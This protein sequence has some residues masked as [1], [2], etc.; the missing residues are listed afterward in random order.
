MAALLLIGSVGVIGYLTN[1]VLLNK[2]SHNDEVLHTD[3]AKRTAEFIKQNNILDSSYIQENFETDTTKPQDI[4]PNINNSN[5]V[6]ENTGS[7]DT[8]QDATKTNFK[9]KLSGLTL[10]QQELGSNDQGVSFQPFYNGRLKQNMRLDQKHANLGWMTGTDDNLM[11][12]KEIAKNMF[13]PVKNLSSVNGTNIYNSDLKHRYNSSRYISGERPFEQIR[14]GPGLNKGYTTEGSGGFHQGNTRDYVMPKNV[15]QLRTLDN[16]KLTY[17]GR[18]AAPKVSISKRGKQ[19]LVFK[20][21]VERTFNQSHEDLLVTTGAVIR[22]AGRSTIIIK[23]T[24]RKLSG[25]IMGN[26]KYGVNSNILPGNFE[27][28]TKLTYCKDQARNL[29]GEYLGQ[30][31]AD[32]HGKKSFFLDITKRNV[33][34]L[35]THTTNVSKAVKALITPI[36]D[37]FK[38]TIKETTEANNN[39]GNVGLQ[40]FRS[41]MKDKDNQQMNPTQRETLEQEETFRNMLSKD[42]KNYVHDPSDVLKT[43]IKQTTSD[44]NYIGPAASSDEKSGYNLFDKNNFKTSGSR[45]E[46]LEGREPTTSNVS[47]TSGASNLNVTTGKNDCLYKNDRDFT[48]TNMY[49]VGN[50]IEQYRNTGTRLREEMNS[51]RGNTDLIQ[52]L[53]NNPYNLSI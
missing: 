48:K 14:V 7:S 5:T 36:T 22:E 32:D 50:N 1:K 52:Q 35:R 26:A 19:G 6:P 42:K 53:R 4:R 3:M 16:P 47:L 45:E 28:S 9:S 31:E 15:D 41:I 49:Y 12:N 40:V 46:T 18:V 21:K 51:S 29:N 24:N 34:E 17:K 44:N 33:T 2:N 30:N 13:E 38:K 43:T 11:K 8:V 37:L 20:N 23:N 39:M 25:N 10:T 27:K